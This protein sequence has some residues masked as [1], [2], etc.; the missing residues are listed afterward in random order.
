ME[1]NLYLS[2]TLNY[3]NVGGT[4]VAVSFDDEA[5]VILNMNKNNQ[6]RIWEGW[7]SNNIN[8]VVSEHQLMKPGKHTLKIW[9]VD[10]GMVL[11]RIIINGGGLKPSYLGPIESVRS[12][13]RNPNQ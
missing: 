7:V 6:E 12:N 5:P 1:V 4:E 11:Q 13:F 10:P 3:F 2:P 8:Q 9:M